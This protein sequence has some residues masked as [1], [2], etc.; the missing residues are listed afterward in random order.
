MF[1]A[2]RA[3]VRCAVEG[4]MADQST[5]GDRF[6][7]RRTVLRVGATFAAAG[8]ALL[9]GA[10]AQPRPQGSSRATIIDSQVHAYAANTPERPWHSVPNWPPH[11]TGDEMVAAMDKVGVDGAIYISPVSMYRYDASY[12]VEV[13][14][15]Y[16]GRFGIIKP[17]DPD[18]QG[19]ADVVA[20]W[21]K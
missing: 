4:E 12:A 15:A 18:D 11:V 2:C 8:S 9:R 13:V 17:V 3:Q 10:Q 7:D 20:E 16:P 6:I 5:G 19:V 21:K 1:S 14:K